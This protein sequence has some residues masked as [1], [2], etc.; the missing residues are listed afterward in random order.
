ML[1]LH[2]LDRLYDTLYIKAHL[3]FYCYLKIWNIDFFGAV[4]RNQSMLKFWGLL[5]NVYYSYLYT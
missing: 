3:L 5:R 1:K 4:G 2:L